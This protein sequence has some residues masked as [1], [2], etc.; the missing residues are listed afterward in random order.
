MAI[1]DEYLALLER[2]LNEWKAYTERLKAEAGQLEAQA[3][4]QFDQQLEL[5]RAKQNEAWDNLLKLK[6]AGEDAWSQ[7]KSQ[8]DKAWDEMKAVSD[9][10]TDQVRKK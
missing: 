3:K 8:L 2:Q 9:R 4:T 7:W 5:I 1:R 6:G 10:L